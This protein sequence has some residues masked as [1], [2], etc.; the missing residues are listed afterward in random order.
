MEDLTYKEIFTNRINF[1][2]PLPD[3]VIRFYAGIN[4]IY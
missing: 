1:Y 4:K 2:G 3:R